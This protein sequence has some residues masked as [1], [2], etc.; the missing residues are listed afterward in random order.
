M[1]G[2]GLPGERILLTACDA[3]VNAKLKGWLFGCDAV[4]I[5]P[6]NQSLTSV[7]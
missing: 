7:S 6:M 5:T 3:E 4:C 1:N 2:L